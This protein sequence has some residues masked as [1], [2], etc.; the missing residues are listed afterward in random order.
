MSETC[1]NP[2]LL[3]WIKEWLDQ[4]RERNSKGVTVYK[5][6]YESMKACPLVFQHPSE[7]QQLNGLGPKLCERLTEKLKAYCEENG[8]PMPEH[9]QKAAASKR[10]SDEGV[11]G[12]PAKKPR[13]AKPY[14]P[15]L[16][17]GPYALLLGLATLDEN[18][19]QGL[20]KAQLI[21]KAQPHCDSSFTAPPDPSKFYTAW[22]SMK[23]LLQ[24]EL[25][26]EHGRPLRK[27]ALTEEGWEVA[28]RIKK[29]LPGGDSN[30]LTFRHQTD[31]MSIEQGAPSTH[32]Q[33]KT[34]ASAGPGLSDNDN[35]IVVPEFLRDDE[36]DED[37]QIQDNDRGRD[38]I[39]KIRIEPIALPANSFT[40]QLVLDTREVRSSKDRHHPEVRALE[41]GDAM[42][43][44][45]CN[46]PTFLSQYGEE[47]NEVMLDWIVERKRM[48]DLLGSIKDG[49]FHEQKFRLRRSGIKNVIYLIEEFAIT[50]DVG[51]ASA[52][53]Y[54]EMMAS[55]I[56]STQVVNGYFVKQT[57]NLDDTIRYLARMTFLLQKMYCFSPPTHTLS[58]I[59]SRQLS[60]AQS[61]LTALERLRARDP[62]V[63]YSV[64]FS[65]FSALTSKSDILS[66]R[67]VFL[68]MLMCTRGVTGEKALEIQKRWSTPREFIE[69]FEKL[70]AKGREDMVF[71]RTKT[72]VGRK[73]MGK[74]LSKKVADIWGTDG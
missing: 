40:V 31:S 30:T 23:T 45:R 21:E 6:A 44:A 73:K 49:R 12:Q 46:D 7:A 66:L 33:S 8:L 32:V 55:A 68:K 35:D 13:K 3:G 15:S 28:K 64:T 62:S 27:Y 51:S 24:K 70:D 65:T 59:P 56:A 9:P 38:L 11:D 74:V 17:S 20:T 25:V 1:A 18:A 47:C 19:S 52:M 5:K 61:Y 67:D 71:E 14:V 43:V 39:D 26:Y 50:H 41:L 54:Q 63:T 16:R 60:S 4:A 22:N 58:L 57:R 72:L 48:D 34:G 29:T 2:L 69:A 36:N 10:T 37:I 53:K 42:W